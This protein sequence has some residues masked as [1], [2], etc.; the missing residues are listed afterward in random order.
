[1]QQKVNSKNVIS[2]LFWSFGERI[3]AQLV[4]FGITVILARILTPGDYGVISLI[5]VFITLANVFVTNGFGESLIQKQDADENEYSTIFWCSFVFSVALYFLLFLSAP[6]ISSFYGLTSLTPLIRVLAIKLPISSLSTIQH[7]YVSKH[8]QFKKFFFS[9]LGGTIISGIVGII[10]AHF[11]FGPWAVVAQYLVNT[12]ID[13]LVLLFTIPWRPRL[14]FKINSAKLL[15]SFG[16][17]VML[18]SFINSA[19]GEIRSLIIGKIYTPVDL[20]QYKRGVQFPQLFI[21]NINAAVSAVLFPTISSVNDDINE[22][23]RLTRKSMIVTSYIIFPLMVG[24]GVVAEPLVKFLLTEKWMPCVPYLRLACITCGLQPIQ[25]A[26]CQAIKSIGRSDVYLKMEAVKKIIG[27]G[28]L[29]LFM[30]KGVMAVA[31]S[32]V[33]A[34]IISAIISVFPNKWLINY[35]YIEQ[36]KDLTPS[37]IISVLMGII[38]YPLGIFIKYSI[39]AFI[40]QFLL[41]VTVYF[42]I[43]SLFQNESFLLVKSIFKSIIK[44]K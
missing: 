26:N 12:A 29:L 6:F 8:M 25:T 41:G 36:I 28:L 13:T 35:S 2:G 15:M 5:L 44:Q 4:T 16:W 9:T 32:N 3:T 31:V 38:I 22:V 10:L 39:L 40:L 33:A 30:N 34:I 23:K 11:G 14:L 20:A 1:M 7:A 24:L 43:S 42:G 21:T 27:I 18:S 37:I 19:Y 17:K